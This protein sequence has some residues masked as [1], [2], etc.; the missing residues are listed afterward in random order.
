M[1]ICLTHENVLFPFTYQIFIIRTEVLEFLQFVRQ[2]VLL[3]LV[4]PLQAGN[5]VRIVLVQLMG[6]RALNIARRLHQIQSGH[7]FGWTRTIA[8]NVRRRHLTMRWAGQ[9]FAGLA[10]PQDGRLRVVRQQKVVVGEIR[11]GVVGMPA[12]VLREYFLRIA[13][14]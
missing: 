10:V 4:R 12:A 14:I 6:G 1:S 3:I 11:V 9:N 8:S 2:L 7:A 5:D 13:G